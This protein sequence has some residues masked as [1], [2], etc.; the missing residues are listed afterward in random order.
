[1]RRVQADHVV[2]QGF[3]RN[4]TANSRPQRR[5]GFIVRTEN[6]MTNT[7]AAACLAGCLF[8]VESVHFSPVFAAF[9]ATAVGYIIGKIISGGGIINEPGK[10]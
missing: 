4:S 10:R 2:K 9:L 7:L 8:V 3:G 5:M 6:K 1:M